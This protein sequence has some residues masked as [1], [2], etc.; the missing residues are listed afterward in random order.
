MAIRRWYVR[1]SEIYDITIVL[2]G[3]IVFVA[4]TF[5]EPDDPLLLFWC[6][7]TLTPIIAIIGTMTTQIFLQLFSQR[8]V[9]FLLHFAEKM[10]K[11]TGVTNNPDLLEVFATAILIGCGIDGRTPCEVA[12]YNLSYCIAQTL[13]MAWATITKAKLPT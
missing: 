2:E 11:T 1:L 6:E 7:Q 8:G 13:T 10:L 4:V 9:V 12:W 5:K 3:E